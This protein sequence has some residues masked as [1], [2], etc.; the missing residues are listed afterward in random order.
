MKKIL[1]SSAALCGLAMVATPAAAQVNLE[2][3]GHFKGYGAYVDQEETGADVNDFDFIRNTEVHF[4]GE[5]TLDNG[6]TVGAHI[7]V[8]AD[9]SATGGDSFG[10]D[11]SYIYFSGS[12]GRINVG[13]EDGASYLLQVAAPSADSNIDGIR[14]FV[15]PVNLAGAL[16][17][18]DANILSPGLI[19]G[20]NS[21]GIDYDADASGKTTKLTYLSPIASGLQFGLS[22]SPDTD[23]A[24]ENGI[25]LDD[26]EDTIGRTYEAAL[27]YE[28]TFNNVGVIA[29]AGYSYG[30]NEANDPAVG[31][32]SDDREQW[33]VGVDLDIGAFGVGV[34]YVED[35]GGLDSGDDEETLVVGVDYTTGPFKL[36]ASYYTQDNT[37]AVDGLDTERY[38]GGVTYTYGPGMTLR[39]SIGYIEHEDGGLSE[40]IDATYVTVGT[41]INF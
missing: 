3:G 32:D 7:E 19:G 23:G 10:V 4:G 18:A 25:G 27:R 16:S 34:A 9:A 35:N 20:Q 40:D 1:L 15:N 14:Q 17:V 13:D 21:G 33:N 30:D 26:V 22:F 2:I 37:F 41:Q 38:A 24:T 11:E 5:T 12:W 8:E 31:I 39:G 28:G 29:G 36:G 6:L